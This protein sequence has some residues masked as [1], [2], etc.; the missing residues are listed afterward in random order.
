MLLLDRLLR[1]F[2][3]SVPG[4][5]T[6]PQRLK[7]DFWCGSCGTGEP[8]PLSKTVRAVGKLL[9]AVSLATASGQTLAH[10]GWAG[11]GI[12][13][14]AWWAGAVLYQIDP[15]SFQDSNGDG[16][17]DL[18]GITQ[19]LDY[20]R[21]LG[22]DAI[23]LSPF[24][25][26]PDFGRNSFGPPFDPKYGT[27][28]DLDHL[29]QQASQRKIR[30]FVDLPLTPVRSTQELVN[31]ARFWLSRGIAGLRLTP[32]PHTGAL[33]PAQIQDRLRELR[34]LCSTYAGQRVIFWDLPQPMPTGHDVHSPTR[35]YRSAGAVPVLDGSQL[36]IDSR[37]AAMP[38][39]TADALRRALD[40]DPNVASG[41]DAAAV[42]VTD[43]TDRQRSFDRFGE[44][45]QAA[46]IAKVMAAALLTSRGAP[47]LYFGQEIGM[48]TMPV[49]G[50]GSPATSVDP[51]PMQWGGD[52]DFTSGVPWM[53]MGRNAATANVALEDADA[54][55]LLNWYRKL[56][57][58]HHE[59]A[60]LRAGTMD[61]IAQTNPD[62][63]AWVRRP[64]DP[65]SLTS[66]VVV[67]CNVTGRSLLVSVSADLR[68]AGVET[69][70]P[71]M[72]TLASTALTASS[73]GLGAGAKDPVSG[74]VSMNAI[75]LPPYGV[76]IGEL[77]HQPGLESAP[78]P[79][80]HS[81]R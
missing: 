81:S 30:I 24:Q 36:Q 28:E 59:N 67:V 45:D 55:S 11:S 69:T 68:R 23:V 46:E 73:A 66:P 5:E 61:L 12:T 75:A 29:V 8:V 39:L 77:A 52:T 13:V 4:Q 22:V 38:G 10:K 42:P 1:L 31:V 33:S 64:R 7:P 60:A 48:A 71:M 20:V 19:R 43:G 17:G 70:S 65:G 80:R 63:V 50:K 79:L 37:L 9:F 78:S 15:V 34:K 6:I 51:T 26:Q 44:G 27:E 56:S 32:D 2:S 76:Y 41:F 14:E 25:L 47:Q 49:P 35:R 54:A 57:A 40:N 53:D 72:R 3:G 16:F 21:S 58:L 18:P 62:I 74:P